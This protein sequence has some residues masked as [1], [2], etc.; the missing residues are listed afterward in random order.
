MS[1]LQA[2]YFIMRYHPPSTPFQGVDTLGTAPRFNRPF[3]TVY[4]LGNLPS[5]VLLLDIMLLFTQEFTK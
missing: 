5:C 3:V 4:N 1:L 2:F